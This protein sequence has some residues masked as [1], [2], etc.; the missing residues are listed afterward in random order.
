MVRKIT[1]FKIQKI[2][3]AIITIFIATAPNIFA[4]EL[5]QKPKWSI[6]QS[7]MEIIRQTAF[8]PD[9]KQLIVAGKIKYHTQDKMIVQIRD[10]MTGALQNKLEDLGDQLV[11]ADLQYSANGKVFGILQDEKVFIWN[12]A[13]GKLLHKHSANGAM[14]M[15]ISPDATK[16]AIS[17]V[18]GEGKNS[19]I[20]VQTL[21]ANSG[22]IIKKFPSPNKSNV[23][24]YPQFSSDG[25]TVYTAVEGK[26]NGVIAW[27]S[28]TGKIL[29]TAGQGGWGGN[30]AI[31]EGKE[32][33]VTYEGSNNKYNIFQLKTGKKLKAGELKTSSANDF[34][35][36]PSGDYAFLSR[37]TP[38]EFVTILNIKTGSSKAYKGFMN[39]GDMAVS[40]DGKKL[41]IVAFFTFQ[42]PQNPSLEVYD[43]K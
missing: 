19:V 1:I 25:K 7:D 10:A 38:S 23:Y 2:S 16:I 9:G 37:R 26:S 43:L 21:D 34:R 17:G 4:M 27:D 31:H 24:T 33:I 36:H 5:S 20:Q 35:I 15:G 18:Q 13:D 28:A 39:G 42:L 3:F 30:F 40:N 12:A 11:V 14:S 32:Q 6:L 41:A 22:K 29:F 8:S